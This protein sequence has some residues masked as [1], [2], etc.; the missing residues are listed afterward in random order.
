MSEVTKADIQRVHERLD[1][2][3]TECLMPIKVGFGK[4]EQRFD[5]LVIPKQPC[6]SLSA[7]LKKHKETKTLWNSS[8]VRLMFDLVKM[9]IVA[10]FTWLFVKSKS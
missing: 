5:D 1:K 2:M 7:H 4:L 9:G 6:K 8:I 10:F 3:V